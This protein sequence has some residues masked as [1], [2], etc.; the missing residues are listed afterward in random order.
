MSKVLT[1]PTIEEV[2]RRAGV[3]PASVSRVLNNVGP[4]SQAL[5]A[6]VQRAVEEV[7]YVPRRARPSGARPVIAVLTPDLLNPY[8]SEVI[9]GI[10]ERAWAAGLL[11]SVMEVLPGLNAVEATAEWVRAQKVRGS[12]VFG[13]MLSDDEVRDFAASRSCPLIAINQV[14]DDRRVLCIN[15]DYAAATQQAANHLLELGHRRVAFITS[16]GT[17]SSLEKARGVRQAMAQRGLSLRDEDIL[18][19]AATVEWGFQAMSSLLG[20]PALE[21]PTAVIGSCDLIAFGVLH[22]VRS[23]QLSVPRD[24][25]VIGFDD[26]AMACHA[27]PPLT[28]ISPPKAGIGRLAV[29]LILRGVEDKPPVSSFIML[30]SPLIVRESTARVA[31]ANNRDH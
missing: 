31:E 20:R 2:A 29:D 22:A 27:N 30:E 24:I 25:S 19:G 7:G 17:A 3:S 6:A 5:R 26:I 16:S 8:F 23:A 9:R 15:I 12:V 13:G 1:T 21:R 14:V 11:T 18:A 4:T 10:E 28:T